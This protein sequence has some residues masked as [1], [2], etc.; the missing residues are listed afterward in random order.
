[1]KSMLTNLT[2]KALLAQWDKGRM[3]FSE[4]GSGFQDFN[5]TTDFLIIFSR[6]YFAPPISS[7][8][9]TSVVVSTVTIL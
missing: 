9:H 5:L 3:N 6:I 4:G 1:M 7:L 2:F 8:V